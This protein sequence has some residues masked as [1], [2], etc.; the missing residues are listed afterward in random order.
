MRN[1]GMDAM[2]E[3]ARS[4]G[5]GRVW[6][7]RCTGI[8]LG[9]LAGT[10]AAFSADLWHVAWNA[11]IETP[12]E[13]AAADTPDAGAERRTAP[14]P[15]VDAAES[16]RQITHTLIMRA[17]EL[18]AR[19]EIREAERFIAAAEKLAPDSVTLAE[20]RRLLDVAKA[21]IELAKSAPATGK[22]DRAD[23][24]RPAAPARRDE[25][26]TPVVEF[27]TG[28]K[29]FRAKNFNAAL[30][31]FGK[32]AAAG[33]APAQNYLGYM[34]RHG[35]GVGQDHAKAL[36]WYHKA[37]AQNHAGALNNIG[38]MHRHGLGVAE[39]FAEARNW[40]RR[41]A[42]RGD[43]AGQYNLGQML[44]DG[45][46][47]APDYREAMK[48]YKAAADQGHARAA[49]GVAH[50]YAQGLGIAADPAE[51]YFWYGVAARSGV[52]G[53]QRF[54]TALGAQLSTPQRQ[55]ADSRLARWRTQS[56]ER[57]AQ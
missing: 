13:R 42:E 21:K 48:W 50:L 46:G 7:Q 30:A 31:H 49:M 53:A 36:A 54:R 4:S 27:A 1:D 24:Q 17:R 25:A 41:A 40:F 37:A 16:A 14:I 5:R 56:A 39:N 45:V 26:E 47:T 20:T 8:L 33:H 22:P 32:A 38:Y 34:Y 44:A 3:S 12:S 29:E 51:A 6:L 57:E 52:E 55:T 2:Q 35:F 23:S 9:G 19:G 11:G 28:V 18:I 10:G 43:P 15:T